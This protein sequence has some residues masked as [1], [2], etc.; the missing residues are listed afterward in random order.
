MANLQAVT[1][2]HFL[3][4]LT[5]TVEGFLPN[6]LS[7]VH[8]LNPTDYTHEEITQIGVLKAAAKFLEDNPPSGTSF[9]PG[10]LQNLDP[11]NP[12]TLF[13]A[14][15]GEVTSAGKLQSAITEIID[16]NS[17]V[18]SDYLS[19]AEYHV[20]GEEIQAANTRLITQ[21]NSIL[22]V[23]SATPPNFEAA[24]SMIGIYLHILQDFYSNTNWVELEGGVPYEDL[25]LEDRALRPV[26]TTV[27]TCQD[28]SINSG[29]LDCRNN[30]LLQMLL[31]SGYK[32]GQTKVKPA[33]YTL[34]AG[35]CSHGGLTDDSRLT[36]PTGGIN[37]ETSVPRLSPHYYLHE[38]AAQAAIQATTNFFIAPGYG[39]LSQIGAESFR[40]VL[41]LGSGNSMV[42]V[43]DVS[44]SMGN[45]VEAVRQET[46]QIVQSTTGTANAP[47]NYVLSTFSDP[48]IGPVLT[49]RDP[50]EMITWLNA[51]TVSGGRDCPEY[52]FS[53]IE[54]ALLNCLPESKLFIFTDAD[55]KDPEKY[56][57]VAALMHAKQAVL[58]FLLTGACNSRSLQYG[59]EQ[60]YFKATSHGA[61]KRSH[62]NWYDQLAQESGGSIYEGDKENIANLTGVISVALSNSAPVTLYKATLP[63]GSGRVVPLEVDSALLELVISLVATNS[64]PDLVIE[65][66][67]GTEQ[68]FGTPDAEIVVNVGTNKVYQIKNPTPGTWRLRL[69]DSQQYMLEVTGKSIVDFSYQFMKTTS[70]GILLPID[71]KPVAGVNTTVI[72]D[73]LGSENVQQLSRISLLSE[74]GSELVSS[75]MAAVGGLLGAKYS[76]VL[77]I[78]TEEFRVKIEGSDVNNTV[79]QRVQPTF[80]Q[81]QSFNLALEGEKEPLYAGGT[82]DVH[83]LLVNHGSSGTF[84]FT[85]TD[86]ASMVQ[87]VSPPSATLQGKA[88]ITGYIRFAAPSTAA[89]GTT[90]TATLTVSGPGGS[91]NSLVV[92]VTV[93]PQIVVTVDDVSPT[94]TIVAATGN[95][96]LEQQHPSTCDSHH[97]SMEVQVK[98]GESGIY[99]L[100][101]SP[102]GSGVTFNHSTFS[103]GIVGTSIA[104]TYS[105]NCCKPS[106]TVTVADK[107]GNIAQCTMDYYIPTT[108]P[109]PT[110][111]QPMKVPLTTQSL[112]T[113]ETGPPTVLEGDSS[114]DQSLGTPQI[115][116]LASA[117]VAV[118]GL[119]TGL[120]AALY[121]I[122]KPSVKPSAV[123]T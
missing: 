99:S 36:V 95:C 18:D 46:V 84:T 41:N 76:A 89:V 10:Q 2:L 85:A 52:C 94:C 7:T 122:R 65:N 33:A 23:L 37:K 72:V 15:Y 14:Y 19:N 77:P 101:A 100:I 108:T 5:V 110:T 74:A 44:G 40:E 57:S 86:D 28:C 81:P 92:R 16:A 55:P 96:T 51:L 82:A 70:N 4:F 113:T 17:R 102:E 75:P 6:R 58:N 12:T 43:I 61:N 60:G 97:W 39:L 109:Q 112:T 116:L 118:V 29:T 3:T 47:Y 21:R 30:I 79:F 63:A 78:P 54:L 42:F 83:F 38:Q 87:S 119:L 50:N 8:T 106:G 13:T 91:S 32:S 24:R 120:G 45:D 111:S 121:C 69:R 105:S 67:D 25:G 56:S 123:P 31:T 90:S 1:I 26:G 22:G 20:G 27:P 68:V 62:R 64:A 48:E 80:I 35:K 59:Q 53:G 98:D 71:G 73:V 11:L 107:Q 103:P 114:D 9:I 88:N 93:E 117:A 34:T 104:A 115:A 66:P 49:T